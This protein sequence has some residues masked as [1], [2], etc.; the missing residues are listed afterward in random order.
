MEGLITEMTEQ[1]KLEFK[2]RSKNRVWD[3][4]GT[5]SKFTEEEAD[6]I[7]RD[8]DKRNAP[9]KDIEEEKKD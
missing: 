5:T 8:Y 9:K 7:V 1:E 6:Q 2:E 3:R 4:D